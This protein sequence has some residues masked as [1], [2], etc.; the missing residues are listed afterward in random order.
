MRSIQKT[1]SGATIASLPNPHPILEA[2]F[3]SLIEV[4]WLCF[5]N[6]LF[7]VSRLVYV[8]FQ[9][10]QPRDDELPAD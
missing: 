8:I 7:L 4:V 6:S 5:S 1:I 9:K 3:H 10:W 2:M